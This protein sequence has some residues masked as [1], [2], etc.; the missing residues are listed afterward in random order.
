MKDL[1]SEN[2]KTLMKETDNTNKCNDNPALWTRRINVI[3]MSIL[4][5]HSTD[6][7]QSLS[8][9]QWHFSQKEKNNPKTCLEPQKKI[10]NSQSNLE[11]EQSG[12]Y[13]TSQFQTILQITVI[14]VWYWHKNRHIDQLKRIEIPTINLYRY[15][16]LI[17]NKGA[18]S[19]Q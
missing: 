2:C 3:K 7:M 12:R 5:K 6:S 9:F 13:N 16:Q 17:F 18:K 1:Y 11:K 10:P 8:T 19:I 15:S 4:S 14:K